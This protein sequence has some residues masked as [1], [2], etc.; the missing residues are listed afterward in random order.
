MAEPTPEGIIAGIEAIL[1]D[2][3]GLTLSD[4]YPIPSDGWE[5][6]RDVPRVF[7]VQPLYDR[8]PAGRSTVMRQMGVE[9]DI[10]Y[11]RNKASRAVMLADAPVFY[12]AF[13]RIG[14]ALAALPTPV[15]DVCL[16]RDESDQVSDASFNYSAVPHK[17]VMVFVLR[18]EFKP[19]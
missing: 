13:R 2:V 3:S 7:F 4:D 1:P 12:D 11:P 10:V 14:L 6:E 5:N 15:P 17:A 9:I 16:S 8:R 19:A 18:L